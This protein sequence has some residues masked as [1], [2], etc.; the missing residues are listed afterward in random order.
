MIK[1]VN[2]LR[3]EKSDVTKTADEI[4]VEKNLRIYI[5]NKF[6]TSLKISP[7]Y[8]KEFGIGFC[9]GEG[10]ID[11]NSI[12]TVDVDV[13]SVNI[14]TD[15]EDFELKVELYLSSDCMSGLRPK[16]TYDDVFVSSDL[17]V[18]AGK[19]FQGIIELQKKAVM[20]QRTGGTHISGLMYG[21]KF[22]KLIAVED[23]SRHTSTDK[24]LGIGIIKG[25]NFRECIFLTSGRLPGDLVIKIARVGIPVAVSRTSV[26]DS[27]IKVAE[28]T[29]VTLIGFAR[30]K[31]MNI[32]THP[33]KITIDK[34]INN[35]Q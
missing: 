8:E 16:M 33:E 23:I 17:R 32:Y 31:R 13:D 20:W 19:I 18:N 30:G 27:G 21:N 25:L 6:I 2:V 5:N 24:I 9:A 10:L 1:K 34:D 15:D 35:I 4:A 22:D 26:L 11:I 3:V 29:G 7:G 14:H 28:N 12:T